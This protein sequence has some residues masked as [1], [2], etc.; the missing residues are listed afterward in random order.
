M[1]FHA[2]YFDIRLFFKRVVNRRKIIY[3]YMNQ[4]STDF[5][6]KTF[7]AGLERHSM[8]EEAYLVDASSGEVIFPSIGELRPP[9]EHLRRLLFATRT[10]GRGESATSVEVSPGRSDCLFGHPPD[11]YKLWGSSL[12]YEGDTGPKLSP[13]SLH[14]EVTYDP[15]RVEKVFSCLSKSLRILRGEL[16][17]HTTLIGFS[18]APW[19]LACYA[20][21]GGAQEGFSKGSA[22]C[23]SASSKV[24]KTHRSSGGHGRGAPVVAG[25]SRSGSP[26]D[27][28]HMGRLVVEGRGRN[29]GVFA[30][31]G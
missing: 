13:I 29:S 23:K 6:A 25:A 18:G 11:F 2:S 24:R 19:T 15:S 21:E 8:Q 30:S 17:P 31:V 10:D 5:P 22:S 7:I 28:R 4:L 3:F 1:G 9:N 12:S 27:F 26:A 16:P 14:E 20:L